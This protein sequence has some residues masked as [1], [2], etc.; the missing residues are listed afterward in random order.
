MKNCNEVQKLII[1]GLYDS[2]LDA[3][4]RAHIEGCP[5]CM[6]FNNK[7][8]AASQ[9]LTILE[10]D[11]L[12]MPDDLFN[13]INTA[14]SIKAKRKGKLETYIFIAAA[15]GILIP[16]TLLGIYLGLRFILY[17]QIFVYLNIPLVLIPL[18]IN[19]RVKEV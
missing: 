11:D 12:S 2:E 19:R 16:F 4:I 7:L 15:L 8:L 10:T 9:R 5:E 3:D 17:L 6:E 13:I 1:D 18:I 14:Q